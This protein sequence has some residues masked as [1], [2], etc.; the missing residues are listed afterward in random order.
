MV[1]SRETR[2]KRKN[3]ERVDKVKRGVRLERSEKKADEPRQGK[4]RKCPLTDKKGW[5]D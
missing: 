1:Q 3:E 2:Q 4:K 5:L